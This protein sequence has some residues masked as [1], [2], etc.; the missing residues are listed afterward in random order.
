MSS[1]LPRQSR[2]PQSRRRARRRRALKRVLMGLGFVLLV[3]LGIAAFQGW[4]I[5]DA[6]FH[7]ERAAVVP[8]PTRSGVELGG[9]TSSG[10]N[11]PNIVPVT[12]SELTA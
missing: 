7:A 3:G 9:A 6:I 5:V 8:L 11:R 12:E 1:E 10:A 4:Q 2:L